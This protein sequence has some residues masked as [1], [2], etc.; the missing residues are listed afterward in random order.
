MESDMGI[1]KLSLVTIYFISISIYAATTDSTQVGPR[2]A[3]AYSRS[4]LQWQTGATQGA[5]ATVSC[6][7]SS[8]TINATQSVTTS[9]FKYVNG[10]NTNWNNLPKGWNKSQFAF[11]VPPKFG[12][13]C[14]V[15][16]TTLGWQVGA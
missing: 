7:A 9:N 14:E 13:T 16:Q 3:T 12:Q 11:K 8:V 6:P 5:A 15:L 1:N 10:I 4:V 2:G